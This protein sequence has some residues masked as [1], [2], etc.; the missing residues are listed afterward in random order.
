ML[1]TAMTI[2]VNA[3][4][5]I[6]NQVG[7]SYP[8]YSYEVLKNFNLVKTAGDDQTATKNLKDCPENTV[9]GYSYPGEGAGF[10]SGSTCADEGRNG[11]S[12]RFYQ[13]FE[14][15]LFSVNGIRFFGLFNYNTDPNGWGNWLYCNDRGNV[16]EN[17]NMTTPIRIRIT[18]NKRNEEG[19][20]GDVVF[21]KEFDVIPTTTGMMVGNDATGYAHIY[22]FDID[23]GEEVKME[24]GYFGIT[25]VDMGDKPSCWF[26]VFTSKASV[27]EA[28]VG[29]NG[30][31]DWMMSLDPACYCLVGTGA[32]SANKAIK[33]ERILS[34]NAGAN[35]KYE[36]VAIEISNAGK[37]ALQGVELELWKNGEL[38]SS[39]KINETINP[40]DALNYDGKYKYVFDKL[41][42]CSSN[43]ENII[44]VKNT[45]AEDEKLCAQEIS[46][47]IKVFEEGQAVES[48]S[49][50]PGYYCIRNVKAGSIDNTT[51][52]VAYADFTDQKTDIKA[53]E[54]LEVT[55]TTDAGCNCGLW[56]DWNN[57]GNFADEGE[58]IGAYDSNGKITV[59]IPVGRDIKPG[60]KRMRIVS[61]GNWMAPTYSGFYDY[62]ETE[63]YTLTVVRNAGMPG[64][65][66]SAEM[67][68]LN[69]SSKSCALTISNEGDSNLETEAFISY[70][71]PGSP[72][73]MNIAHS[74]A[75]A[76]EG[77][78]DN[79][80]TMPIM[81]AVANP[82]KDEST[83]YV[84]GYDRN[85]TSCVSLES[86]EAIFGQM[87]PAKMLSNIA[88]MKISSID[89]YFGSVPAGASIIIY[90]ENKN[91]NKIGNIIAE[92]KFTP[93]E[94][95]WNRVVLDNP[96]DITGEKSIIAA[97]KIT[98]L[99]SGKLYVGADN[100]DAVI[101]YGDLTGFEGYWFSMADL[102]L[103][104]NFCIRANVTGTKTPAISW[105]DTDASKL[106]LGV[107]ENGSINIKYNDTVLDSNLYSAM[108]EFS[109]NDEL[110]SLVRIPV[111]FVNDVNTSV[112]STN[113]G[114]ANIVYDNDEI[115]ISSSKELFNIAIYDLNGN[116][117]EN[118][119]PKSG[120]TVI[121]TLNYNEG[122]Y[123]IS[124]MYADGNRQGLKIPVKR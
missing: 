81:K 37:E 51:E 8:P 121:S 5:I 1:A 56:V 103:N 62:G 48:G 22:Q 92:Q 110:R 85:P 73:G 90:E 16:D 7:Q 77:M 107:A 28:Y 101:G 2:G 41:V 71:L 114:D 108:I 102:G 60:D 31:T 34:P 69:N 45:F 14:G 25:A 15:N 111:Y 82:A 74:T 119:D 112:I 32:F 75:K 104:S 40:I 70:I 3:Q 6:T 18:F 19:L 80:K 61:T 36:K 47:N 17:G 83:Q 123:L 29:I 9:F 12:C 21:S 72:D 33:L 39:E 67:V 117:I 79:V 50:W 124:V 23:F 78:R 116:K 20:P 97:V 38:L 76:P 88:G 43:G 99:E 93:I 105:L 53:G 52:G 55:I 87:Y 35:G 4:N 95:S 96:I 58:L 63:D 27:G 68:E 57:N 100:G 106:N 65:A 94:G 10:S 98:G 66:S 64:F 59:R 46:T 54:A 89:V 44:T 118:V 84:L 42:D 122:I 86:T 30:D 24:T 13:S 49:L 11:F 113:I 120:E 109:T 26:N 91:S 115:K